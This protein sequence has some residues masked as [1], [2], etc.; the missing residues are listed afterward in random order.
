M[1]EKSLSTYY[2]CITFQL[3][4]KKKKEALKRPE[5][6]WSFSIRNLLTYLNTHGN[7]KEGPFKINCSFSY[8]SPKTITP[9]PGLWADLPVTRTALYIH[10]SILSDRKVSFH[11]LLP[12][13]RAYNQH[14]SYARFLSW[15]TSKTCEDRC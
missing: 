3:V 10:P 8:S 14:S 11:F 13:V 2:H 15:S 7:T 4:A 6:R 9:S 5:I 1:I 12:A